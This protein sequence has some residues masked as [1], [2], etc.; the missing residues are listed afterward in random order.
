[1]SFLQLA[2]I[3]ARRRIATAWRLELVLFLGILLSVALLSSSVVFSDLLAEAALRRELREAEAGE[4]NFWVRIFL[5]L[6]EPTI[7]SQRTSQYQA[8]IEVV[9]RDVTAHFDPYLEDRAR[10][11]ETSTFFF[12]GAPRFEVHRDLRPRGRIQFMTG[13]FEE[14][15]SRLLEGRWPADPASVQRW[16]LQRMEC[17]TL[18]LAA[19]T[20]L[21]TESQPAQLGLDGSANG[22]PTNIATDGMQ[23]RLGLQRRRVCQRSRNQSGAGGG[24]N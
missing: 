14:D 6:E 23:E 5:N 16:V 3:M 19:Q 13:L 24:G 20:G 1:M 9:E 22:V 15:R 10:L 2:Y 21:P 7:A 4:V 18:G 11:L 12:T 17:R 8:S